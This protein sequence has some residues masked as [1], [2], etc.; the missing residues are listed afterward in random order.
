MSEDNKNVWCGFN[1]WQPVASTYEGAAYM[2]PII[3][4]DGAWEKIKE[5]IH[6]AKINEFYVFD[7][8]GNHTV[9]VKGGCH[10]VHGNCGF[11]LTVG[12]TPEQLGT[13]Q[14]ADAI[15]I[16]SKIV[17]REDVRLLQSE[18]NEL[19]AAVEALREAYKK[20]SSKI[21]DI[22]DTETDSEEIADA[23]WQDLFNELREGYQ[24]C[25]TTPQQH[26]RQVRA[27]AV[28][29]FHHAWSQQ[30]KV[31]SLALFAKTYAESVKAG[32]K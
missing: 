6:N 13:I 3:L 32:E 2:A 24:L 14:A 4:N 30:S 20:I 7:A 15:M 18:H 27:E 19:A 9:H 8:D 25:N 26:L 31:N 5:V 1:G 29:D 23:L 11:T 10:D 12:D 22:D 16:D 28:L 17:T 21:T